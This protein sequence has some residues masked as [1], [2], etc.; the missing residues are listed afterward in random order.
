[1]NNR[2]ALT[3]TKL[4]KDPLASSL[5]FDDLG[6]IDVDLDQ[7]EVERRKQY[8]KSNNGIKGLEIFTLKVLIHP[9]KLNFQKSNKEIFYST[10]ISVLVKTY[11]IH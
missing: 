1:M 10:G 6:W 8:L 5:H 11:Q 3:D 2:S 4:V 7:K 9:T